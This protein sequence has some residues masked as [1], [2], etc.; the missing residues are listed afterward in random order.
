MKLR[1]REYLKSPLGVWYR[2]CYECTK[3]FR[4]EKSIE[5]YQADIPLAHTP[6]I[7]GKLLSEYW[8]NDARA[9]KTAVVYTCVTN[10]YDDVSKI[11][12]P[13]YVNSEWDYV[14]FTDNKEQIL[15]GRVGVWKMRPLSFARLDGTRNNRWHKFHPDVLF[16]DYNESIYIDANVDILTDWIFKEALRRNQDMLLPLHPHR[17]CIYQ[18]YK[19]IMS[20]FMDD[21]ELLLAERRVVKKSGMPK[22]Y[23]MTENNVIYRKHNDSLVKKMM[24]ECWDMVVRYSKRDQLCMSWILWKHGVRIND[25]AIPNVRHDIRD[26]HVFDHVRS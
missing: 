13:S 7:I 19:M 5:D 15:K 23:G 14:C 16:P 17:K 20:Q 18:E 21:P 22:D 8:E 9:H 6:E 4:R 26:F 10:G 1:T 3:V 25:V 11:A 2:I 12:I 24:A